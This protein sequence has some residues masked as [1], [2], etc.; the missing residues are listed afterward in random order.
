MAETYSNS[1]S[2]KRKRKRVSRNGRELALLLLDAIAMTTMLL[3]IFCSVVII[4]CQYISPEKSGVLS[5]C[6]TGWC[7]GDGIVLLR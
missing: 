4:V 2:R 1:I 7:V 3:L 6:S 5:V